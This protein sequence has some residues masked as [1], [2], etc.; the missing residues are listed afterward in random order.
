MPTVAFT[1]QGTHHRGGQYV[2][3]NVMTVR[4]SIAGQ[5]Q[6]QNQSIEKSSRRRVRYF[7]T[8][9]P[10]SPMNQNSVSYGVELPALSFCTKIPRNEVKHCPLSVRVL[11]FLTCDPRIRKDDVK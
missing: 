5:N 3:R 1:L 2:Y 10:V 6:N 9:R 8:R 11:P 4:C 7:Y